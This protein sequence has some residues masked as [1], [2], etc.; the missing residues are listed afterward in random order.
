MSHSYTDRT[1]KLLFGSASHCAY[2]GCSQPLVF[3]DRDRLTVV[4]QIAHIRSEK[5]NGPRHDPDYDKELLDTFENLLLLCGVHHLPVDQHESVYTVE[6]LE[7]WKEAQTAQAG[8]RL[9]S[10]EFLE[11][12]RQLQ[13][14][15][16]ELTDV[17]LDVLTVGGRG[18]EGMHILMAPLSAAPSLVTD[19]DDGAAYIGVRTVNR[20][21]MAVT[22]DASGIEFDLGLG[23]NAHPLYMFPE[24]LSRGSRHLS[25]G[26]V[27]L[28]GHSDIARFALPVHIAH[29]V[30]Q[31]KERS[32]RLPVRFRPFARVASGEMVRGEWEQFD[33]L[34]LYL[35]STLGH[36]EP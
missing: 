11:I 18:V 15:V 23:H 8:R 10:Q 3:K 12:T 9:S 27:R 2:P 30:L 24:H 14:A 16:A 17:N 26:S 33:S 29:C 1:L 6:E 7:E 32:G 20:G 25:Q 35:R 13:Q 36:A 22:I 21:L 5:L 19:E 4:A 31:I 28:D 34:R